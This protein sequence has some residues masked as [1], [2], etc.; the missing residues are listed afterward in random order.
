MGRNSL[1]KLCRQLD[2][3]LTAEASAWN[4]G[5]YMLRRTT[6][7]SPSLHP[8]RLL[9]TCNYVIGRPV[10]LG[11]GEISLLQL[12]FFHATG[13]LHDK[14][15]SY[16]DV[17]GV[18]D[19]ASKQEIKK[20]FR[21]LAKK[22]HPDANKNNPS[23]NK[24]FLEIKEAYETLQD[25]DKRTQYNR[26][27]N[28]LNAAASVP[29]MRTVGD[30]AG[31]GFGDAHGFKYDTNNGFEYGTGNAGNVRYSYSSNTN[32][33]DSFQKIFSEIFEEEINPA[34]LDI[35]EEVVLSFSEA[36]TGCK[37]QLS[38]D[39]SLPCDSCDGTGYPADAKT[40]LC[41]TCRGIGKV[42]IPPF[43][44]SC[45]TCKGS[46]RIIKG[47]CR[48]CRGSGVVECIKEVTVAIP[49]GVDSGDTIRVPEAGNVGR[50][51][52]QPGN[53]FI[54]IK[55]ADD[56]VF[57]RDG[58]DIYV[59]ANISF[60]QAILRGKIEVPTLSGK[61]QVQ[62]PR[63]VQHGQLLVLRR[64][65][66][67]RKGFLVNH[68][69]QYVRFRINLPTALNERQR[70]LLEEFAEEEIKNENDTFTVGDL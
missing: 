37:K 56:P 39:A 20:A 7:L 61:T 68:G 21:L 36:A 60:T 62:I 38:F 11:L 40:I 69:D 3:S 52:S 64:K 12:R 28:K 35:Q 1:L 51:G 24:K 32:F 4:R 48:S 53:L 18:P 27:L 5:R 29:K 22:Y 33:S 46:G 47:H 26:I 67:P 34:S 31:Y 15:R 44:T 42:T 25:E 43:I 17:L 65:G 59:D 49:P 6:T 30:K 14:K 9:Q 57:T 55:V 16:Y 66:L 10:G 2:L 23:A 19:N 45:S 58:A 70:A 50:Q 8:Y 63:E 13:S 54:H 41:P